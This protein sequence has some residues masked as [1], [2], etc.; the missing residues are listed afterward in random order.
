MELDLDGWRYTPDCR[1]PHLAAP[2][3]ADSESMV[4]LCFLCCLWPL[5]ASH[6][7]NALPQMGDTGV[8][9]FA[10]IGHRLICSSEPG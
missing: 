8:S 2:S 6:P 9:W 7:F 1:A 5:V 10:G 3:N 4:C